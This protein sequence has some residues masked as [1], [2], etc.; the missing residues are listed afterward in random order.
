[1]NVTDYFRGEDVILDKLRVSRP[2][3]PLLALPLSY[4]MST[5]LSFLVVNSVLFVLLVG[6]FFGLA[7]HLLATSKQ[8]FYAAILLIFAFPVYYRGINVTVDLA[9][10]LIF[11]V[12]ARV[13]LE[14][15]H[16]GAVNVAAFSVVAT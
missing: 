13:L 12:T 16:R 5:E 2:I 9:S 11:V 1:M 14:L 8:A 4:F 6:V 3:V 15:E 7:G 10:W